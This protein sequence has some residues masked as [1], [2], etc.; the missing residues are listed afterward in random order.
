MR[1]KPDREIERQKGRD[2]NRDIETEGDKDV[3]RQKDR[4]SETHILK[5]GA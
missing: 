3:D 4:D 5:N 1:H 2:K